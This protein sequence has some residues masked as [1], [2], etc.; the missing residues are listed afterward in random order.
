M[1]SIWQMTTDIPEREQLSGSRSVDAAVIGGGMAGILTAYYLKQAGLDVLVIEGSRI[2]SGQT[3]KTTAKITVSHDLI[4]DKLIQEMGLGKAQQYAYA[5][6]EAV[7]QYKRLIQ[8]EGIDCD[9][10]ECPSYLYSVISEKQLWEETKAAEK[11]G[12]DVKFTAETELPFQVRAALKYRN[13]ARM[14]PLKFLKAVSDKIEVV[15]MTQVERVVGNRIETPY[16]NVEAEHI[17][18]ASH[19]PFVNVPG[20]YF[21]RMH[22]ERS[23][24][25][26]LKGC[27]K[28]EGMY[29]GTDPEPEEPGQPFDGRNLSFRSFQDYL[30]LGGFGHRTGENPVGGQYRQLEDAAKAYW[31]DCRTQTCWSAQDCVTLD[32][33]PYI[34]KYSMKTANWYVAA[35]FR[36]WGMT[37]S[38]V[39]AHIIMGMITGA[40]VPYAEVFSPQR[41]KLGANVPELFK[42]GVHSAKS[43]IAQNFSLPKEK[44]EEI[45]AGHGGIVQYQ[46]EK[47]GVYRDEAGE[48]YFVTTRCPHLGCQLSWNPQEKSWDCPCHGSR[49]DYRGNLIDN[50]AQEG[51]AD[52]TVLVSTAP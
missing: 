32:D 23:Y 40:E 6:Q 44:V 17:I 33:V 52:D 34:G 4:Y 47:I 51:I 7:R 5:N 27:K 35:G 38:M 25:A 10:V 29:L 8:E 20:F 46:G 45:P 31:P 14:H 49:F 26:A 2:G 30:I 15:E 19:F 3:G 21:M 42:E 24:V 43:L 1:E 28:M 22:Q 13:Q 39:A 50:P 36:K 41:F 37:S 9:Y 16:G 11:L 48:T 18:F 12:M